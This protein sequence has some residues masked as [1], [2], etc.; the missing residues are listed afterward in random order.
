MYSVA[1]LVFGKAAHLHFMEPLSRFMLWV[2]VAAWTV[3]ATAF[4]AQF[5]RRPGEPERGAPAAPVSP[6]P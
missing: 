4:L 6:A 3:V 1:T 2:A 5:V